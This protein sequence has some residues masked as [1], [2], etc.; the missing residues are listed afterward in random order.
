MKNKLINVC[1]YITCVALVIIYLLSLSLFL[2][3][4]FSFSYNM[5]YIET[6]TQYWHGNEGLKIEYGKYMDY[7]EL[8]A[9]D[10]HTDTENLQYFGKDFN[11]VYEGIFSKT[12]DKLEKIEIDKESTLYFQTEVSKL[13]TYHKITFELSDPTIQI[14]FILNGKKQETIIFQGE[15]AILLTTDVKEENELVLKASSNVQL[16]S[17]CFERMVK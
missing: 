16:L 1:M 13:T 8:S 14:D 2:K 9:I 15:K 17:M 6:K 7:R 10:N 3:K 11:F 5:Y 4:D 12:L